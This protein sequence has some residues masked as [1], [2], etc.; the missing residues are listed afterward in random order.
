[1]LLIVV[2]A[3]NLC[4]HQFRVWMQ[5]FLEQGRGYE[6]NA[7]LDIATWFNVA[8]DVGCLTT[9]F[10]SAA[11]CRRGWSVHG[12]RCLAFGL[13]ALLTAAGSLIPWL[14]KG[15]GLEAA[16]L[17]VGLGSLGL[18]PCYYALSQ[19]LSQ[20]HQGKITGTLGTIAW[21]FPS[22]WHREFGSWVDQT[23]S[24]DIG[25]MLASLMPLI[26]WAAMF[27]LWPRQADGSR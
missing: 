16:L 5:L 7:A 25:M 1:V 21:I 6:R 10:A 19:E 14:P 15:L 3:I 20:T 17:T 8:T 24:Y 13:C 22:L 23:K 18:F 12:A 4:W 11:L 2:I 26:A 27:W 9:G